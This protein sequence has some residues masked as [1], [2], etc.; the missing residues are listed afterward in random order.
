MQAKY[1]NTSGCLE[2][3]SRDISGATFF[4]TGAATICC[5]SVNERKG[6]Y[7]MYSVGFVVLIL[8]GG[9]NPVVGP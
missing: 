3:C 5:R 7:G 8:L 2:V 4:K 1:R 9:Q 6:V